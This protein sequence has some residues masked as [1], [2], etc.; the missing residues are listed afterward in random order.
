MSF[1]EFEYAPHGVKVGLKIAKRGE[2]FLGHTTFGNDIRLVDMSEFQ[3]RR[4]EATITGA[5]GL[6]GTHSGD[7][8][9]HGTYQGP[10][11]IRGVVKTMSFNF[12][13]GGSYILAELEGVRFHHLFRNQISFDAGFATYSEKRFARL[14]LSGSDI[15]NG[16]RYSDTLFGETGDDL[17]KGNHGNDVLKGGSGDD[18]LH[19]GEGKDILVGGSGLDVFDFT[20]LNDSGVSKRIAD[21][22]TDFTTGDDLIDL[23]QIDA[24]PNLF[25]NQAFEFIGADK[26]TEAG[27]VRFNKGL[28]SLN[29]DDDRQAEFQVK[30]KGV[31]ELFVDSLIL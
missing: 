22:I 11:D 14:L 12:D 17:I 3:W 20:S 2:S 15:I 31:T 1:L 26:F 30:L 10:S 24:N 29:I 7:L 16:S 5:N 9:L 28:L 6:T 19:G 8:W 4:L 23:S 25:G 18:R 21:V 27:Q 13:S